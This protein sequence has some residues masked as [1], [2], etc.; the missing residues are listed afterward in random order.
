MSGEQDLLP[1]IAAPLADLALEIRGSHPAYEPLLIVLGHLAV[2]ARAGARGDGDV[3]VTVHH[4]GGDRPRIPGRLPAGRRA[5][6]RRRG[7]P[8]DEPDAIGAAADRAA[9]RLELI[10]DRARS[11]KAA[12]LAGRAGGLASAGKRRPSGA[13]SSSSSRATVVGWPSSRIRRVSIHG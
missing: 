2:A 13:T 8:K 12:K 3:A 4:L 11:R 7:R 9:A 6:G 10:R 5:A 1:K